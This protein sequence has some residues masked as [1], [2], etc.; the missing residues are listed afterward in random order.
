MHHSELQRAQDSR[1]SWRRTLRF[2]NSLA[3]HGHRARVAS[4]VHY[5]VRIDANADRPPSEEALGL[6][7]GVYF[8]AAQDLTHSVEQR[9]ELSMWANTVARRIHRPMLETENLEARYITLLARRR[10]IEG[11]LVGLAIGV[12]IE[13]G[14]G[15]IRGTLPS[16][17]EIRLAATPGGRWKRVCLQNE[18]KTQFVWRMDCGSVAGVTRGAKHGKNADFILGVREVSGAQRAAFVIIDATGPSHD[19]PSIARLCAE[20]F[21]ESWRI[22][23]SVRVA[24]V[25]AASQIRAQN[26]REMRHGACTAAVAVCRQSR[27]EFHA[28]GD[29]MY[30]AKAKSGQVLFSS[31]GQRHR[32]VLG[33]E[34]MGN[35]ISGSG[36]TTYPVHRN[37][38]WNS[39]RVTRPRWLIGSDGILGKSSHVSSAFK[40]KIDILTVRME[41]REDLRTMCQNVVP[42]L[43]YSDASGLCFLGF[44]GAEG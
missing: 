37:T 26:V 16:G 18:P 4:L 40:R 3:K 25:V 32:C 42:Q 39:M 20:G 8:D 2:A 38:K 23:D 41:G 34:G 14:R 33:G 10:S 15:T 9:L 30:A 19:G 13:F 7:W 36:R 31:P 5:L 21:Y 44:K 35:V 1:A 6:L 28:V 17:R 29:A 24:L 11:F 43:E 12:P 27:W 22:C